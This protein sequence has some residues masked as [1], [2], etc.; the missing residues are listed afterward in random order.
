MFRRTDGAIPTVPAVDALL[1]PI[2]TE[3]LV[4]NKM[5]PPKI[6]LKAELLLNKV[7]SKISIPTL[8]IYRSRLLSV[9]PSNLAVVDLLH[10]SDL[11]R[12]AKLEKKMLVRRLPH[13]AE[14]LF[15]GV[16]RLQSDKRIVQNNNKKR[17]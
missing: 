6:Q 2:F 12:Y 13:D 10:N 16:Y 5:S 7:R 9:H 14:C 3:V 4:A 11:W 17:P 15:F 8:P 1:P